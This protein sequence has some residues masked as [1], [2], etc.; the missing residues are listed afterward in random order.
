MDH[1]ERERE[2][3]RGREE[4]DTHRDGAVLVPEPWH[5]VIVPAIAISGHVSHPARAKFQEG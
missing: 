5:C 4:R 2:R 1:W 3:E